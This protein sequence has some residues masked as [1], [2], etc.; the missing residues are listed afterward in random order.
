ML[1]FMTQAHKITATT[2]CPARPDIAS[3]INSGVDIAA[4]VRGR[5]A[6]RGISVTGNELGGFL[7]TLSHLSDGKTA[8]DETT[9]LLAALYLAGVISNRDNMALHNA[10]LSQRAD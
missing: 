1:T 9:N 7:A 10:Y 3:A 5:A 4:F 6:Q 8:P 2:S